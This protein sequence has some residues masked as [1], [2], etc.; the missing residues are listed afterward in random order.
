[1]NW[2]KVYVIS[3]NSGCCKIGISNNHLNRLNSLQASSNRG[4]LNLVALY[5]REKGDARFI[6]RVVHKLLEANRISNHPAGEWFTVTED[7]A[8]AAVREAIRL[9]DT[10]GLSKSNI[11]CRMNADPTTRKI[12]TAPDALWIR[13]TRFQLAEMAYHQKVISEADILRQVIALGMDALEQ[14]DTP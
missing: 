14:G 2:R 10:G 4:K 8:T 3:D 13:I 12:V 9:V 1:M 5:H 6:E 11:N 7:K